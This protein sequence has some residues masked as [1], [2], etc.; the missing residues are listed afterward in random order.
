VK[1][2]ALFLSIALSTVAQTNVSGPTNIAAPALS[3]AAPQTLSSTNPPA[4]S[5]ERTAEVRN[6]CIQGR[7]VICGRVLKV[8]PDGL[9][10]ESGYTALLKFPFSQ[11]WLTSGG[12]SVS[13]DPN[14]MELNEPGSPCIGLVFL[15]DIP[16]RPPVKQYDYVAI[17]GY[18]VGPYLYTS[19]PGVQK[20]IRKFSAG[21][22]TAVRM[23]LEAGEK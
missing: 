15:V 12:A 10:V 4:S 18:P 19:V 16:K 2:A 3:N 17:Q 5:P 20:T 14:T 7:R 1:L 22:D 6:A 11:S 9:V 23:N 13:R 8:L 21:L